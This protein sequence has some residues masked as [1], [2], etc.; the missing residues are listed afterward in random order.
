MCAAKSVLRGLRLYIVRYD[1][2]ICLLVVVLECIANLR[3][4]DKL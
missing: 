3:L 2:D 1:Y 4:V